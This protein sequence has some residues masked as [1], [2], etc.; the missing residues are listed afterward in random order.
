MSEVPDYSTTPYDHRRDQLD[1]HLA[2]L[3]TN[4]DIRKESAVKY[5]GRRN[6]YGRRAAT[7]ILI[8]GAGIATKLA[9]PHVV[10]YGGLGL[11]ELYY[12]FKYN[13]NHNIS[14][15][16]ELSA[17]NFAVDA[18]DRSAALYVTPPDWAVQQVMRLQRPVAE[19]E[20]TCE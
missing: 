13:R 12:G 11:A 8:F 20:F 16:A 1:A 7:L 9:T 17:N 15:G 3:Q 2:A 4:Y 14:N 18:L 6:T 10:E 19:T 5:Q